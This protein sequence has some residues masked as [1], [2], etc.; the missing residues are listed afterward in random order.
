[1]IFAPSSVNSY[2]GATFPGVSDAIFNAEV[3][4]GSWDDVRRQLDFVR[5]HIRY[6]TQ[7]LSQSGVEYL[8]K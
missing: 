8:P 3:M 1:M 2:A 5:V 6:A 4:G 7:I